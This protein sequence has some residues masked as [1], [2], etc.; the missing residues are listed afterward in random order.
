MKTSLFYRQ[1]A[2]L[3]SAGC[4]LALLFLSGCLEQS[5]VWSPDGQRA[6]VIN[7]ANRELMLCAADGQLLPPRVAAVSRVAWLGDSQRLVLARRHTEATWSGLAAAMSP[8]EVREIVARAEIAWQKLQSGAGWSRLG[9][10]AGLFS[11]QDPMGKFVG[12][13]LRDQ[14]GQTLRPQ[15]TADEW[16]DLSRQ[17][18]EVHELTVA[19]IEREQI[20]LGP[21]L[22]RGIEEIIEIRVSPGDRAVAFVSEA[23][24]TKPKESRLRIALLDGNAPAQLVSERVAAQPDWTTDGRS[25]VYFQAAGAASN[26][27]LRLGT[28]IRRDVLDSSGAIRISSDQSYLAGWI[29]SEQT[30][31]RCLRDGRIL[32]NAAEISLPIA[33]EDYGEQREQL[34]A[35]DP[36]RQS[37]LVRMIPRKQQEDLPKGLA[38]FEV[39]PDEQQ[40]LFGD[41]SGQVCVLTLASGAVDY[42]QQPEKQNLQGAPVWRNDGSF[43]YTRRTPAK[44]GQKPARAAEVVLRRGRAETVLSAT[45]PDEVVNALVSERN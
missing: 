32:F 16:D 36:V 24:L 5:F 11:D 44:H 10:A 13:Y 39:S 30:R 43:T 29:F 37:T 15:L 19:R 26:D 2:R 3:L 27:D 38:F 14:R 17:T 22:S 9:G 1:S 31:V 34:F 8:D 7:L 6:V 4:V 12:I 23:A 40:V 42:V 21:T 35:L 33:A 41:L 20:V 28:L 18:A 25:L 45:W